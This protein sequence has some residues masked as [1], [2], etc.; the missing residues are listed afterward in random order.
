MR[1][2]DTEEDFPLPPPPHNCFSWG[3]FTDER[4][5][6]RAHHETGREGRG[7]PG[8]GAHVGTPAVILCQVANHAEPHHACRPNDICRRLANFLLKNLSS[9][10]VVCKFRLG[11]I[12]E[13]HEICKFSVPPNRKD[14]MSLKQK[15]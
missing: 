8:L 5:R 12:T 7:P 6:R 11:K 3:C 9:V 15:C 4:A 13:L 10:G 14:A 2:F 1:K